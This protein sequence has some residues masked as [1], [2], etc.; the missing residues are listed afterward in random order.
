MIPI[1]YEKTETNFTHNGIGFLKDCVKATVTETRNGSFELSFQY[2]ITGQWFDKISDGCIIK[3]KANDKSKLQ[4][5]RI[6]KSSKPMKGMITYSAEHISYA[7][8]AIPCTGI[9][10]TGATPQMAMNRAVQNAGLECPF[11]FLSDISTL[12][13]TKI[14][15]PCSIRAVLGG[16]EG[17]VL[18]V[19]G[20]EYEFDNFNVRLHKERGT[21]NGVTVQY[22]KN[23]TDL[24]QDSTI[25]ECY[26]H[27]MPYVLLKEENNMNESCVFLSE[28]V[29]PVTGSENIGYERALTVNLSDEFED[30]EEV[31]EEKLRAKATAYAKK[32]STSKPKVNI[33]VSFVPLW[34]TEEY[35]N[36]APLEKVSLCDTVTVY[37]SELGVNAKA[38]VIETV[39]DVLK[40]KYESMTLG[41]A[42][43]SFADTFNKQQSE[44]SSIKTTIKRNQ[45]KVT[46]DIKKAIENATNLI[47]GQSG[48]YVVLNPPEKPQEIL[49]LDEPVIEDALNV[50]RFNSGG[51][52]H[53]STGY[54]GTYS[55][56]MTMDGSIVADFIRSG[57][58]DGALIR[59]NSIE[60][61]SISQAFKQEIKDEYGNAINAVEQSFKAA[62]GELESKISEKVGT[63]DF[64]T[65]LSQN[66][67]SVKIA[68]NNISKYIQFENGELRIYDS[69]NVATQKLVSKFNYD[70]SHFYYEGNYVGNIGTN[71]W[72]DHDDYRGLVFELEPDASYMCWAA[73]DTANG[74]YFTKLVY[75]HDTTVEDVGLHLGCDLYVKGYKIDKP[76]LTNVRT[77][78]FRTYT[79]MLEVVTRIED[80]GDGT[81]T[82]YTKEIQV[83][84]G[85]L[86]G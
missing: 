55:I 82:W 85:I 13:S 22:G 38:K 30:G 15:E 43:S 83:E 47:T 17:S 35:K 46:E 64:G 60:S 61:S 74:N 62:D 50:W 65:L 21:D 86:T 51:L 72:A 5:F 44:I 16:Q 77:N 14:I 39:Y 27:I 23:M 29:L 24:N 20:G 54:N 70:G 53:S 42:K 84:N 1:L 58:I 7:L 6:Y 33:K 36:I 41:D 69:S 19:W 28:K 45:S 34:Q 32:M 79:G 75:H 68:W 9:N 4:L 25:E 26:T 31:T 57:Q 63:K 8:N 67:T 76:N 10:V 12:N 71:N 56:A 66:S 52:G 59:A 2:P 18:D 78:G 80:N 48:G 49:I 3:A 73:K 37:Y 11:S 81:I 40:E